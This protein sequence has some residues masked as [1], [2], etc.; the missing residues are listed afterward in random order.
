MPTKINFMVSE[1]VEVYLKINDKIDER[2]SLQKAG[3]NSE[4]IAD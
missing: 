1:A 2:N 4:K 3:Q